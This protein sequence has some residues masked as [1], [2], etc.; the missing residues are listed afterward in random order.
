MALPTSKRPKEVEEELQEELEAKRREK[1]IVRVNPYTLF[2][3]AMKTWYNDLSRKEKARLTPTRLKRRAV[4]YCYPRKM[5]YDKL[6]HDWVKRLQ[7]ECGLKFKVKTKKEPEEEIKNRNHSDSE[8]D[9]FPSSRPVSQL[10]MESSSSNSSMFVM[11][12]P[13]TGKP[14]EEIPPPKCKDHVDGPAKKKPKRDIKKF[15]DLTSEPPPPEWLRAY[16]KGTILPRVLKRFSTEETNYIFWD[17]TPALQVLNGQQ[18]K[19]IFKPTP[20]PR[21]NIELSEIKGPTPKP[22]LYK[23]SSED[24]DHWSNDIL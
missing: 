9:S 7:C 10:S 5:I 4:A 18:E 2:F 19:L 13:I 16:S 1:L 17:Y 3:E 23:H 24:N 20:A 12:D 6:P 8:D 21:I 11:L 22:T 15:R 14:T